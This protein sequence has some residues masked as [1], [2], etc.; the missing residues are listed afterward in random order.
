M[1]TVKFVFIIM[2]AVALPVVKA[3]TIIDTTDIIRHG[4]A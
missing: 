3:V 4:Q 2:C 1:K